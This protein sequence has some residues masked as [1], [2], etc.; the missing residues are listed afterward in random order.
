M[1]T[2]L[3]LALATSLMALPVFAVDCSILYFNFLSDKCDK[4][5]AAYDHGASE[6]LFSGYSYHHRGTY[7]SERLAEL[8]ERAWGLGYGKSIDDEKGDWNAVYGLV[9]RESHFKYQKMVGYGWQTYW[10]MT[11]KLKAGA[12]FTAFLGS[13]P[14]IYNNLPF[15]AVLPMFSL[16]YD[17]AQLLMVPIPKVSPGTTGNGNVLFVFGSYRY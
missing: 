11:D 10:N 9:F 2:R 17:R 16:R 14:D 15:P 7:T 8:N 3:L 6:L 13:R 12:G 5:F 1:R 4:G